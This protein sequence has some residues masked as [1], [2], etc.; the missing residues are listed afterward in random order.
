MER[1]VFKVS[2]SMDPIY[3]SS[4]KWLLPSGSL[5]IFQR[6]GDNQT[7]G[8]GRKKPA[9]HF[10]VELG[11]VDGKCTYLKSL[12]ESTRQAGLNVYNVQ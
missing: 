7:R 8:L 5:W 4:G 11:R 12:P 6:L 1:T 3:A 9:C 2:T 10:R